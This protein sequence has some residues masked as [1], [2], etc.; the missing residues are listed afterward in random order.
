MVQE[1]LSANL[2]KLFLTKPKVQYDRLASG[3]FREHDCAR[4]SERKQTED[5]RS[6]NVHGALSCED[7]NQRCRGACT[8]GITLEH[9]IEPKIMEQ[10]RADADDFLRRVREGLI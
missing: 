8:S 10:A 3:K 2:G 6:W 1:H 9:S 5:R 7:S 4:H